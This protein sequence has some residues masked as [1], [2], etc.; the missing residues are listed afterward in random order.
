[1]LTNA[2][3][4]GRQ[5]EAGKKVNT[6]GESDLASTIKDGKKESDVNIATRGKAEGTTTDK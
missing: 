4:W 3:C 2:P 5:A 1:M 6:S